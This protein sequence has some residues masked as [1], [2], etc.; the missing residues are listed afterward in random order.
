MN[1][2]LKKDDYI[3]SFW[4]RGVSVFV[5]DI[6]L[7]AYKA[8]QPLFIID[9][10]M[11]KQY[12]TKKAYEQALE[13]GLK[14]YSDKNAFDDYRIDLSSYCEEFKQ[15]FESEIKNQETLSQEK[16]VKF[17][18]YTTKLCGDYT[19]MNFESTDKSFILQYENPIIR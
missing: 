2:I 9:H 19:L 7:E 17:F 12:F 14:F 13:R 8:I 15:F 11:F 6:H 1:T 10:G 5:T 4:V 18:E 16:V 3:M